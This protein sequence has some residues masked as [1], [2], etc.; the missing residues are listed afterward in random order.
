MGS[1]PS[2]TARLDQHGCLHR[3]FHRL[4]ILANLIAKPKAEKNAHFILPLNLKFWHVQLRTYCY[5][6]AFHK[7]WLPRKNVGKLWQNMTNKL[8]EYTSQTNSW[9]AWEHCLWRTSGTKT[10]KD[11]GKFHCKLHNVRQCH[12]VW[13]FEQRMPPGFLTP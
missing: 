4:V 1:L 3:S 12:Y 5:T 9:G 13:V 6:A 8:G 11:P 2:K 10:K 7:Q